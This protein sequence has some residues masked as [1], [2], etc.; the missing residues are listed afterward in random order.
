M[1][2]GVTSSGFSYRVADNAIDN[3]EFLDALAELNDE[4]ALALS[5]I[6]LLLLG[7]Q[8]R[9]SLYDHLRREDGTVPIAEVNAEILDILNAQQTGKNSS[10]SPE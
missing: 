10:S 2:E 1:I 3:M 6:C 8:Q 7:K 5:K 4:D 9:R